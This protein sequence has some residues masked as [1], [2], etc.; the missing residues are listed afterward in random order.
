MY[1][2]AGVGDRDSPAWELSLFQNKPCHDVPPD[3][4]MP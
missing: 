4:E 2:G 1:S 3:V